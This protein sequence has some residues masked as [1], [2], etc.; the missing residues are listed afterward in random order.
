MLTKIPQLYMDKDTPIYCN[1]QTRIPSEYGAHRALLY[2]NQPFD[3][4][5][6]LGNGRC[7]RIIPEQEQHMAL[8]FGDY[9]SKSLME[10]TENDSDQLRRLRGCYIPSHTHYS[11]TPLVRI[12]SSCFTGE[13]L[14][15]LR[16]DCA[17]QLHEAMKIMSV[18]G[19]I[20]VYLKQEGRGIGLLDKLY[21]YNLIDNGHDTLSANQ[22]LGHEPDLRTYD[23]ASWILQD[24]GMKKIRLLTNNPDKIKQIQ[25]F[26]IQVESVVPMVPKSWDRK[27]H[28]QVEDRDV[29]LRTKVQ[30]MGHLLNV[31]DS[32]EKRIEMLEQESN[33][34]K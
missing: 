34:L 28:T 29:Y 1:V 24:L 6:V 14:G 32:L 15:S 27:T 5:L 9:H 33:V 31:P 20:I 16:C 2:S 30:R 3:P 12:H 17:E 8:V 23:V 22:A 26:G 4:E 25:K 10:P 7:K 19:G 18:E 21:A 11:S 13:T